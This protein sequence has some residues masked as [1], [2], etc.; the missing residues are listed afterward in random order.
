MGLWRP[1]PTQVTP[2]AHHSPTLNND[3]HFKCVPML[4]FNRNQI[5]FYCNN[6]FWNAR[7]RTR[8]KIND[9]TD[10][11]TGVLILAVYG[12]S[13]FSFLFCAHRSTPPDV[14]AQCPFR[15]RHGAHFALIGRKAV[16]NSSRPAG[17]LSSGNETIWRRWRIFGTTFITDWMARARHQRSHHSRR[18]NWIVVYLLNSRLSAANVLF[19]G[20]N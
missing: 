14:S 19:A 11:A 13:D 10:D 2:Q 16:G 3:R 18:S 9:R 4:T 8:R 7:S 6:I 1:P 20:G 12:G 15:W 17:P 5:K